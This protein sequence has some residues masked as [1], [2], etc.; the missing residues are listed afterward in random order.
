MQIFNINSCFQRSPSR[1]TNYI[2]IDIK[3]GAK[4]HVKNANRFD[5]PLTI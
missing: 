1:C 2:E 4:K 5:A 3:L